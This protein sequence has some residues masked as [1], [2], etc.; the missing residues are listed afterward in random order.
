MDECAEKQKELD[1]LINSIVKIKY[2]IT[3]ESFLDNYILKQVG[4]FRT[5]PDSSKRQT[6]LSNIKISTLSDILDELQLRAKKVQR[7]IFEEKGI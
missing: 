2:E 4:D 3:N 7:D 6:V 1:A 5:L